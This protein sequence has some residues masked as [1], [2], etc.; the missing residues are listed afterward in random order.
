MY[1]VEKKEVKTNEQFIAEDVDMQNIYSDIPEDATAENAEQ[2]VS[3][4]EAEMTQEMRAK[5]LDQIKKY[6]DVLFNDLVGD[7]DDDGE[8][9]VSQEIMQD[10]ID[11]PKKIDFTD[12][13]GIHARG[14]LGDHTFSFLI[15]PPIERKNGEAFCYLKLDE[16]I[17]RMA[18]FQ[19]ETVTT[20]IATYNYVFDEFYDQHVREVFNLAEYE[21]DDTGEE[22]RKFRADYITSRYDLFY[23]MRSCSE[24]Y[25]ERLE[26]IYFNHRIQMLGMEPELTAILAEFNKKRN[27]LD[28]Y[29]MVS[30]RRFYFLNQLLDEVLQLNAMRLSTAEIQEKLNA[31]DDKFIQK[32]QEI[33]EKTLTNP[34]VLPLLPK[35]TN[36]QTVEVKGASQKS[37]TPAKKG[38]SKG[39]GDKPKAKRKGGKKGGGKGKGKGVDKK[40]Q[41]MKAFIGKPPT[42][43]PVTSIVDS[44]PKPQ[45]EEGEKK[46]MFGN[47]QM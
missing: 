44:I 18:G 30:R 5:S 26:E 31:I 13:A 4:N 22:G 37:S 17:D 14:F 25:Y 41:Q 33:K 27:K 2:A 38:V 35:T 19:F 15:T 6:K 10:L 46:I 45:E 1:T 24:D 7:Y 34:K 8:Y 29:F 40:K 28:V 12:S 20:I 21:S 42:S 43:M 9:V 16:Q 23:A 3:K 39:G 32:S 11:M 47:F 36:V